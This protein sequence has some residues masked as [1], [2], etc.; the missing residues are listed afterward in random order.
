MFELD[1]SS[2]FAVPLETLRRGI[3]ELK[4]GTLARIPKPLKTNSSIATNL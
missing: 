3:G 1:N 2:F 4:A